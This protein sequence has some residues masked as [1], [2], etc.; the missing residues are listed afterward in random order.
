[1]REIRV[2]VS[3]PG[4]VQAERKRIERVA[5]RLSGQLAGRVALHTV[6]WET[7]FYTASESF[8][9]QIPEAA[10]CDIVIAILRHRLGTE[11]PAGFGRMPDGTPYPSGTAYEVLTALEARK[12]R[13]LPDVFVFRDPTPPL[14]RLDDATAR[15]EAERQWA[16][17]K[18]FFERWFLGSDGHFRA[19][20]HTFTTADDLETQVE[21]LLRAWLEDHLAGARFVAWPIAVNGS[22][23]RGLAAFGAGHAPVFFG[24]ARDTIR[25]VEALKDA[26]D[27]G[28]PHLLIVGP[29]GSG[30]SSLARAGLVPTV[31]APGTVPDVDVWRVAVFRPGEHA[32]GP[33]HALAAQLFAGSSQLEAADRGRAPALPE[34]ADGDYATPT[35]LADLMARAG[36]SAVRPVLTV[37]DRVADALRQAERY[38]RPVAA[39]LLLVIDQLDEL[40]A[41]DVAADMRA[42]F[43]ALIQALVGTAR[44]WVVATVRADFYEALVREPGLLALKTAGASLDLQPPGPGEMAEIVR[45]PARAADLTYEV[46]RDG[47]ALDDRILADADRIDMLPLL[48]FALNRL[49]EARAADPGGRT[50]LTHDAYRA[51]GGLDGAIDQVAERA[52]A[53]LDA[54]DVA[55]LPR[56][57][58]RLVVPA[59]PGEGGRRLTVRSVPWT[60][61]WW[62]APSRRLADRLVEARILQSSG[63]ARHRS[64]RITHER[65]LTSW[66]R[67]QASVAANAEFFRVRADVET[68]RTRWEAE[69][70]R[71]DR[72][73]PPGL[74]LAEAEAVLARFAEDMGEAACGFIRVSAGRARLRQ[75]L[76][77][78]AA[79]VFFAVA[80]A[81]GYFGVVAQRAQQEAVS[82]AYIAETERRAAIDAAAAEEAARLEAQRLAEAE[83][84]A[85]QAA[86]DALRTTTQ[87][88]NTLVFDLAQ[89]FEDLSVP[90]AVTRAILER[91]REL[92]DSLADHFPDDPGLQRSRTAALIELGEIY[93]LQEDGPAALA[94]F[95]EARDIARAFAG[96]EPEEPAWQRRLSMS[97]E[98]I[99]SVHMRAGDGAAA[100]AAYQE[101]LEINRALTARDPEN[102]RW[103]NAASVSLGLVGDV[104]LHLGDHD[105]ALRAYQ[106]VLAIHRRLSVADPETTD[107]RRNV[108]VSLNRIGDLHMLT[109]DVEAALAAY[110]ESIGIRR[111]LA[112]DDPDNTEFQRDVHAGLY[113]LGDALLHTGDIPQALTAHEAALD[114]AR[115]LVAQDDDN[116][117]WRNDLSRSLAALGTVRR[118]AGDRPGALAALGE[119]LDI[120]RRLVAQDGDNAL[121]RN[122][123][124]RG[125]AALGTVHRDAG[126]MAAALR[127]YREGADIARG[128]IEHDPEDTRWQRSLAI[129]LEGVGEVRL[130]D[131]AFPQALTAFEEALEIGRSLLARDPDNARWR[132]NVL[133][134][135]V[136]IGEIRSELGATR[137]AA[138]ANREALRI[139]EEMR[140]AG[141]PA[142]ADDWISDLIERLEARGLVPEADAK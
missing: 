123:L 132:R 99:G 136:H 12:T 14:V 101:A 18:A 27:R 75:R 125:L 103:Q 113:R 56:L 33:L 68:A 46:D 89:R 96:R 21:R 81:A 128:L 87:A 1:M 106:E 65:V 86:E 5:E 29:S 15:T 90:G 76:T 8:Q 3:S 23:F 94:A 26:A 124:S 130:Q 118:Y 17:V 53:G 95:E 71:R 84:R 80:L 34:L 45:A 42:T 11:L 32:A 111:S 69:G 74:A 110:R 20:F 37:L 55:A 47:Q 64:V 2:F 98:K 66:R 60:E 19:A 85:R 48:Q 10:Q 107:L 102:V 44:V 62:D 28:T 13:D 9:H 39:R 25:A 72:L 127:A 6:R 109:G 67:A 16:K 61:A 36:G 92:Q 22:P 77:A 31:T 108:T 52:L 138:A 54:A 135:L 141:A 59:G 140:A 38:D 78:G 139:A 129:A 49:F 79:A 119:A 116:T 50:V 105:Q 142:G 57:L 134:A 43:A 40:F 91:A 4:D 104:S 70:R 126:D 133:T 24:R 73:I 122:N 120:A 137:E 88:A 117:A 97:L 35:D 82:Q 7:S 30:K 121:W 131:S 41:G 83:M 51:M 63:G 114:I 58:R 112:A 93:V 115:R 100:L